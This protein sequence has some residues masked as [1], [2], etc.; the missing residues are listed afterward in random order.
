M[1][2]TPVTL[3]LETF[4]D[5]IGDEFVIELD[6]RT[7]TLRLVEAKPLLSRGNDLGANIR[8]EPFSL[9]FESDKASDE[10]RTLNQQIWNVCHAR[11]GSIGIFLV[12]IAAGKYQAIF[13]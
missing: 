7:V 11:L 4:Q 2:K 5:C 10:N 12:P 6:G 9:V 1:N 3:C 13:G 8:S